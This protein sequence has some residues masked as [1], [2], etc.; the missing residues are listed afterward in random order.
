MHLD[1]IVDRRALLA[2]VLAFPWLAT[3]SRATTQ[4]KRIVA[5]GGVITEILYALGEDKRLVGVDATSMF[6]ATALQAYPNI[7]YVRALSAEG[8]LSLR[9]D[10]LLAIE[11]A[12]PPDVLA[13]VRQAGVAVHMLAEEPSEA[14]VL[15]RIQDIGGLVGKP[16]QAGHLCDELSQEFSRLKNERD[17]IEKPRRVLFV[18]SMQNGRV[19]VAGGKTSAAGMIELAGGINAAATLEGF[20]PFSDEGIVAAAPDV[21]IMMQRGDHAV[22]PETLFSHPAFALTPAAKHQSLVTMDGLYLLGFG[23]RTAQAARD[24][25]RRILAYPASQF[26]ATA[27]AP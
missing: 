25:M 6:P 8:I 9:P 21:I 5:A 27:K 22:P 4:P 17:S 24:L 15:R 2:G 12:G 20:K 7:G 3:P 18:L 19:L 23:P 16:E 10:M 14:G 26:A 1:P 13:L 11:S